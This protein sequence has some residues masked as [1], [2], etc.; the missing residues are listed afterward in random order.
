MAPPTRDLKP[1]KKLASAAGS[2]SAQVGQ[3]EVFTETFSRYTSRWLME[4]ALGS[5]IKKSPKACVIRS[6]WRSRSVFRWVSLP[7]W[8]GTYADDVV[9][10]GGAKVVILDS[11]LSAAR[12]RQPCILSES[13]I[14]RQPALLYNSLWILD[15]P[16]HITCSSAQQV[17]NGLLSALHQCAHESYN[18]EEDG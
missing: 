17:V 2:C 3:V 9:E 8:W 11:T 13:E 1:L 14:P 15:Y 4:L 16:T 10:G 12:R 6:S 5:R 18:Q 7:S